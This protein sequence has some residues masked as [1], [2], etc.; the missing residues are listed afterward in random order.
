MQRAALS[1]KDSL[2]RGRPTE[3]GAGSALYKHTHTEAAV[4]ECDTCTP[5]T[6]PYPAT[7]RRPH[8]QMESQGSRCTQQDEPFQT[9]AA[10]RENGK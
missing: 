2:G 4:L 9:L 10:A 7:Q 6:L 1:C 8:T 5:L 3:S